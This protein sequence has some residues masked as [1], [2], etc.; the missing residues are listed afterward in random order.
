MASEASR[1]GFGT[2]LQAQVEQDL[3]SALL[4]ADEVILRWETMESPETAEVEVVENPNGTISYPWD[5]SDSESDAFFKQLQQDFSLE[6]WQESEIASRSQ[7]FFSHLDQLW[8]AAALQT[9]LAQKFATVP[10]TVLNAIAAQAQQVVSASHTL[11]DQLVQCVQEV[12][13]SWV[14][15]DL[16]VLA[17]PLAYAMR[18]DESDAVESTLSSIRSI[19]WAELSETEQARMSL[20]VARYA[21][22]QLNEAS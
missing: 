21:I 11:A 22:D 16:R 4:Q 8:S 12:L 1:S 6:D 9:S 17:R 18:G 7:S 10:Q 3:A 5:P 15:E 20:A 13:P 2:S 14:D 19:A